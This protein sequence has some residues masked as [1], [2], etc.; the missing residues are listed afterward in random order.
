MIISPQNK[1]IY[2]ACPKTGTMSVERFLREQD[3]TAFRNEITINNELI[4]FAG[5]S[6]V[7]SI[8]EKLQADFKKYQ[9]IGFVRHPYSRIVSSYF[10]YKNGKPMTQGSLLNYT[11]SLS[12]FL[13]ALANLTKVYLARTISFQLWAIVFPYKS[14]KEFFVDDKK[15]LIVGHIGLFENLSDDLEKIAKNLNLTFD[16]SKLKKIN[17]SNH[18]S[19]DDYFKNSFFR[20]LINLKI[21]EDL[22]FYK[23]IEKS[24]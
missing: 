7:K 3:P 13:K 14:N 4:K 18:R 8:K 15:E 21:K 23:S 19:V 5:H 22:K 9:V 17:K 24:K 20:K 12:I 16:F 11:G 6:T 10:F 2:L 1:Y